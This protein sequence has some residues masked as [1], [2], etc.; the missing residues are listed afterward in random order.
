[1]IE[2]GFGWIGL[3][4][5]GI[6]VFP[7]LV[8]A[9]FRHVVLARKTQGLVNDLRHS[10]AFEM[11]SLK[12][13]IQGPEGV[14]AT[15]RSRYG[16]NRFWLPVG[17]LVCFNLI[18]FSVLWDLLRH[19]F[20]L[21]EVDI[22]ALLYTPKTLAA[23][24]LPLMAFL[25]VVLFS[26]SQI[27]RRLYV[28]DLTTQVFWNV[29][30]RTVLVVGLSSVLAA[31]VSFKP[32]IGLVDGGVIEHS[33]IVF[34]AI[35]FI[36]NDVLRWTLD[37]AR[38]RFQIQRSKVDELPLSLIQGINFWHEYRLEEEGIENV[39]NLATCDLLDLAFATRYNLRTLV[40]WVDQAVLIHRMGQK[41]IDLRRVGFISGAIDMAWGSPQASP[42]KGG[43]LASHIA[44]TL[45][46]DP[47]YVET[48][49]NGLYQDAQVRTLWD[50]WQ[51]ELNSRNETKDKYQ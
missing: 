39:Q 45:A 22:P 17:S 12:A 15:M 1:M 18:G 14:Q 5:V 49:M 44:T 33:H 19:R 13:Q 25:G 21:K 42:E 9:F 36:V 16:Y 28:W 51:S 40:D 27:L 6:A 35:G 24:E 38:D 10:K 37:R 3:A 11:E 7:L 47:I 26:H 30:Q 4:L 2:S 50:L 34:F 20:A 23:A 46:V 41:A 32:S 8:Y 31:S 29:L 48:L 43:I